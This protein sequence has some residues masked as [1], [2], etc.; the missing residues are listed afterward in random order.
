MLPAARTLL[1]QAQWMRTGRLA[2]RPRQ[3]ADFA[4]RDFCKTLAARVLT[5]LELSAKS[6]MLR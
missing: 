2:R 6:P 4:S 3:V 5:P 1:R